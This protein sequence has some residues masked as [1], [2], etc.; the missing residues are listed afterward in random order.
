MIGEGETAAMD[1]ST[2]SLLRH[3]RS[4][5]SGPGIVTIAIPALL[6]AWTGTSPLAPSGRHA[7]AAELEL[8]AQEAE[9]AI[10]REAEQ[11]HEAHAEVNAPPERARGRRYRPRR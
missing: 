5:L 9:Q 1:E 7:V 4:V 11:R 3:L 6:P 10:A 2:P 8:M